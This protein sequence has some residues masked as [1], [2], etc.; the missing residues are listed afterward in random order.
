MNLPEKI[1][2]QINI[3]LINNRFMI[4]NVVKGIAMTL[5]L[6]F[7]IIGSILVWVDGIKGV[8]QAF[9]ACLWAG[10]FLVIVSVFTLAVFLGNKYLLEFN[11][12]EEGVIMKSR[13]ERAR[14]AHRLAL[15]LGVLGRNPAGAGAGVA[16]IAGEKSSMP[17]NRIRSVKVY[18][19]KKIIRLKRNFLETMFV[20]CTEENFES[21]S[22]LIAKKSAENKG[23]PDRICEASSKARGDSPRQEKDIPDSPNADDAA[24]RFQAIPH[25]ARPQEPVVFSLGRW[26]LIMFIP[27]VNVIAIFFS[28]LVKGLKI[29]VSAIDVIFIISVIWAVGFARDPENAKMAAGLLGFLLC[30]L[31]WICL[32]Y[33]WNAAKAVNKKVPLWLWVI[34]VV[35]C[36]AGVAFFSLLRSPSSAPVKEK[37]APQQEEAIFSDVQEENIKVPEPESSGEPLLSQK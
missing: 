36:A 4:G 23:R 8:A 28:P 3:P 37:P 10:L 22:A 1:S 34:L 14:F 30:V 32:A 6:F 20:Y 31:Y 25:L 24:R 17:W 33:S 7:M 21:V 11:I 2:W 18:P 27:I 19:D 13:S 29:F 12:N 35:I 15:I 16:G 26:A 5:L 9:V